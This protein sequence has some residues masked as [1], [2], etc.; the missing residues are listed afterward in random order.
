M[1]RQLVTVVIP[2][3]L[4][5]PSELETIS[6]DQILSVLSR[7]PITFM[8]PTALDTTWYE[9]Y[10]Q[11]KATVLLE[12][13]DWKG[14][15]AYCELMLSHVFY[16]RFLAYEYVLNCHLDAFVFRDELEQWC[17]LGYDYIG[18]VIY[19]DH[20]VRPSTWLRRLTG[21]TTPE[22]FGNGGFALKKVSTFYRITS[23]FRYYIALYHVQRKLRKQGLYDDIFLANHFP[24]LS[25]GFRIPRKAVAQQFSAAYE[26]WDEANLPFHNRD[27]NTLPFGNHGWIQTYQSFW[28]PCIRRCG[29]AFP[30]EVARSTDSLGPPSCALHKAYA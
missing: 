2:V 16:K 18:S 14:H 15:E 7:Y 27:N 21:F 28:R 24:K 6:L 17:S 29:H 4:E 19:N 10:C 25:P 9:N 3:H 5:K 26:N 23:T 11:G 1:N 12:R 30:D 22:Y 20:W 13:F 8:A